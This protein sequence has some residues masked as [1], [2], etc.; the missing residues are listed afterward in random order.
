MNL[1][2]WWLVLV[3]EVVCV[4]IGSCLFTPDVELELMNKII[5]GGSVEFL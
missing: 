5:L 2:K 4:S 3:C 1:R